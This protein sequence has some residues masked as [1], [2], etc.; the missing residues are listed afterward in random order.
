MLYRQIIQWLTDIRPSN[1]LYESPD[2][3]TLKQTN[4]IVEIRPNGE[5]VTLDLFGYMFCRND[6]PEYFSYECRDLQT[7]KSILIQL[8]ILDHAMSELFKYFE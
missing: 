5:A 8:G 3:A 2:T 4:F 1:L 7:F 6:D